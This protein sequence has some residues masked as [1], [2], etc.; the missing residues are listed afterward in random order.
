MIT[1]IQL[2]ARF[3]S[4]FDSLSDDFLNLIIA[5]ACEVILE[6][7]W[8]ASYDRGLLYLT[9]H[10]ASTDSA[11]GSSGAAGPVTS[12]RIGDVSVSYGSAA[13]VSSSDYASTTYGR[14]FLELR[15][16]VQGGPICTAYTGAEA[17]V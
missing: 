11:P 12:K 13:S 7:K 16:I 8:G 14:R 17:L 6:S 1:A 5:E 4:A 9:A 15:N 3:P 2:K 10:L